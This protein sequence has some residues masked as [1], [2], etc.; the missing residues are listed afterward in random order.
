M[1][2]NLC[3]QIRVAKDPQT[4]GTCF[5]CLLVCLLLK[6]EFTAVKVVAS[7]CKFV[8]VF[9]KSIILGQGV[10]IVFG[11]GSDLGVCFF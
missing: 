11:F 4:A 6:F 2:D 9:S 10:K 1:F 3:Y 7:S 5:S 8:V